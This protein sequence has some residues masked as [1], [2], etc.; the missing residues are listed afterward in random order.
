MADEQQP[1]SERHEGGHVVYSR[2]H[3]E[4]AAARAGVSAEAAPP[5]GAWHLPGGREV[6]PLLPVLLISFVLLVGLVAGLG[7]LSQNELRAV[8]QR[9]QLSE[10]G[11]TFEISY[12]LQLLTA[13]SVL[14]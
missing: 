11:Q 12:L 3:K 4:G 7:W 10:R 14:E 1:D 9:V 13:L 2:L 6:E 8:S 5:V